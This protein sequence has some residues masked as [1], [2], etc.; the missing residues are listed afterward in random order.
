MLMKYDRT[1]RR[2]GSR[3]ISVFCLFLCMLFF[4]PVSV[5]ALSPSPGSSPETARPSVTGAL[6]VE[7]V[8][9]ADDSGNAVQLRGV[10]THGLTW[11]PEY[12]DP[13][14]FRQISEDWNCNLVRLAMYSELYC[15]EEREESLALMKKGIDAA[16]EADVYVLVD[17]HIL[18]DCDPN[19]H[20]EEA[21]AFFDLISAEYASVP[22]LI[23]EICNEPNGETDWGDVL[24]YSREVIP[25]IR[26]NSPEAVVVVGTPEYDRNLGGP[27]LRPLPYDNVMYVLHFYAA[28]HGEG[29]MGE[30]RAAVE[31]GLP[32]FIS[33]CGICESTGDGR[34]DF[35]SA[36][37][38]FS[39]LAEHKISY[40]V[41]SLSDKDETSAFFR[42]GTDPSKP[43]E[44]ADLTGSGL[45][46][47]ELIRG[48]DPISIPSPADSIEKSAWAKI[49]SW[50]SRSVGEGGYR[51]VSSWLSVALYSGEYTSEGIT[52]Q[53]TEHNLT[54][55]LDEGPSPGIGAECGITIFRDGT[56]IRVKGV[57]TGI[58]QSRSGAVRS[59]TVEIL[60]FCGNRYEYLELLYDRI[61]T[62]PQSLRRDFGV[63]SHLWQN[64]AHRVART[65]K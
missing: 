18:N 24:A 14:L 57:V 30:L 16:I 53:L 20:T 65:R 2:R 59:H 58:R 1:N 54:V 56:E 46:V 50:I 4:L 64:I 52:T 5:G 23:Y 25:V 12:V 45:W 29:L 7:G 61:P 41:W 28:S 22:N 8:S 9:L 39:Y 21:A 13:S 27:A 43:I 37:E 15:G 33:E 31:S 17:W 62:L 47:R 10:S 35:A 38:W 55:Y 49:R 40:A 26:K 19:Q 60:D 44:D 3:K 32:V 63:L 48:A 6:H 34:T 51:P 42:P 36:A 11:F